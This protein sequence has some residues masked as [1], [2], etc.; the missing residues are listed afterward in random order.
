MSE[1]RE[2]NRA[3]STCPMASQC[4]QDVQKKHQEE[5]LRRRL[6]KIKHKIMVMSGKG[7]VGKTTVSVNLA[8]A[9]AKRGYRV[10][11][12][13]ADIHGPNVPLMLGLE[14]RQLYVSDEGIEPLQVNENLKVVSMSF[15]LS[16]P[17]T[18]VIWRGPLKMSALRQFLS[19]VN[20]GELDFLIIDLPPGTGD[21]PLSIAQLIKE[22][23]GSIIVTTPQD[24]ALLDSRKSIN[25]SKKLNVPV[26]GIIENMSGL[27]CPHCGKEIALFK[28]GGGEKA[29]RE[30]GVPFLGRIPID[31]KVVELE[32]EGKPLFEAAPDS[33]VV[34]AFEQIVDRLLEILGEKR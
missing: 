17:D 4:S 34:K 25:F 8:Y 24:V 11:L 27:I 19:E 14:G 23:D 22:L 16:S 12:L 1:C 28:I 20:W 10:G 5:L 26:L 3:C 13:D 18:P 32:D 2:E 30:Y 15:L 6:S 33:P 29:A 31:P 9:L 21:E 7:G